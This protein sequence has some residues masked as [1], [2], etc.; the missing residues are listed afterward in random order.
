[1]QEY[2]QPPM[3]ILEKK[4]EVRKKINKSPKAE[5]IMKLKIEIYETE[6]QETEST[7]QK[8][9]FLNTKLLTRLNERM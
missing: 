5:E 1:M 9:G 8:T 4:N 3:H 7:N 2:V 6:N